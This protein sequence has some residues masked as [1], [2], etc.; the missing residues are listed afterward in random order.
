M[1]YIVERKDK[2]AEEIE[3]ADFDLEASGVLFWDEVRMPGPA[4][5]V[6]QKS[7]AAFSD[8]VSVRKKDDLKKMN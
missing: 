6:T 2:P 1:K 4:G 5:I 8:F 7:V 3:A